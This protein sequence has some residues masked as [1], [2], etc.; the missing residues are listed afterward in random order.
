M[1]WGERILWAGLGAIAVAVAWGLAMPEDR[2]TSTAPAAADPIPRQAA[3]ATEPTDAPACYLGAVVARETVDISAEIEG[4]VARVLV[5]P[6]DR[7][8]RGDLVVALDTRSLLRELEIEEAARG[9]A[10]AQQR[11]R[12]LERDR[13]ETERQR[14]QE[15]GD[16]IS[17]EELESSSFAVER[18]TAELEAATAELTRAT[19]RVAQLRDRLERSEL[20]AHFP[21][22]VVRRYLDPG[23]RVAPG[24]AVVALLSS[25]ILA[26]FAVPAAR[27]DELIKGTSVRVELAPGGTVLEG[28]VEHLAPEIDRAA[29]MIFVEAALPSLRGLAEEDLRSGAR[30]YVTPRGDGEMVSCLDGEA[31]LAVLPEG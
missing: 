20:R 29:R 26:R 11:Q 13:S 9:N 5:R 1:A 30:A 10:A 31:D 17:R 24:T 28:T 8:E 21:G 22:A 12:S 7:V 19:A 23:A 6:G 18:A 25:E 15:L 27:V 3:I 16:L 14:R 2:S 4:T